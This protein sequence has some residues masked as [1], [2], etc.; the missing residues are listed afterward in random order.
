MMRDDMKYVIMVS[1]E[2]AT[3]FKLKLRLKFLFLLPSKIK[4]TPKEERALTEEEVASV[5]CQ[6]MAVVKDE[7]VVPT[8]YEA[9]AL[10]SLHTSS[11]LS[12]HT[13]QTPPHPLPPLELCCQCSMMYHPSCVWDEAV[14]TAKDKVI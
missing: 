13:L 6:E 14:G 2:K 5:T 10:A 8:E 3:P 11:Q 12:S 1:R 9:F 7:A 4:V